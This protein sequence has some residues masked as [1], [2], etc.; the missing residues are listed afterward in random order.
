M[1][2]T[3]ISQQKCLKKGFYLVEKMSISA[4]ILKDYT[5]L[6]YTEEEFNDEELLKRYEQHAKRAR[7]AERKK[8]IIAIALILAYYVLIIGLSLIAGQ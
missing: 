5:Y 4:A 3:S 2:I 1:H 8:V 6:P 7:K